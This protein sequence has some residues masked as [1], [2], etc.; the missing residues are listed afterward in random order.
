MIAHAG[1]RA[2]APWIVLA[3]LT[4]MA[5]APAEAGKPPPKVPRG[6]DSTP[7]TIACP[8]DITAEA[9]SPSGTQVW[10]PLSA[11]DDGDPAPR[12]TSSP[13]PNSL[14]PIGTTTVT[15][16]ATDWK[17]NT[18]TCKFRVTVV[19]TT[20]PTI[21]CPANLFRD[22]TS[23]GGANVTF[24]ASAWDV[25]DASPTLTYSPASGSTFA[26][27]TTTVTVTATDRAGNSSTC[28][29]TVTYDGDPTDG[30]FAGTYAYSWVSSDFNG[31]PMTY[32]EWSVTISPDGTVSGSGHQAALEV[33]EYDEW[34]NYWYYVADLGGLEAFGWFGG[35]VTDAGSFDASGS[36]DSWV[37]DNYYGLYANTYGLSYAAQA[38]LDGV[39]NLVLTYPWGYSETWVK[40]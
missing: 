10:F 38:S 9:V 34:G 13:A 35:H 33:V 15:V 7:P 1:T 28:S 37:S 23:P 22:S 24:A 29:F 2:L 11:T 4:V 3:T 36:Y 32:Y 39:G 6:R 21:S 12:V 17:A 40:Q 25:A 20:P 31:Q 27:G 8:G 30:P 5:S 14:F 19:D 16:T 26:D 18:S